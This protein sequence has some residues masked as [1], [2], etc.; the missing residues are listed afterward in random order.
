MQRNREAA[1]RFLKKAIARHGV[2]ETMPIDRSEA[3]AAVIRSDNAQHVTVI[4][5]RQVKY[6]NN[7]V[8]SCGRPIAA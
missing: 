3:N 7:T 4:V 6:F 8:I 1:L 2:P 5:T